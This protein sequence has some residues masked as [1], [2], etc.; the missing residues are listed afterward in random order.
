MIMDEPPVLSLII[1]AYNEG[2]RL[3]QTLPQVISFIVAQ[4]YPAEVLVVNNNSQD[5]TRAMLGVVPQDVHL[6]NATIEDNLLLADAHAT[7]EEIERACAVAQLDALMEYASVKPAVNQIEVSPFHQQIDSQ[8]FFEENSISVEAWAPFAEGRKNIFENE[9]YTVTTVNNGREC[10]NELKKGFNGI[11]ILD[12]MM[13]VMDR[14][15]NIKNMVIE[16][17]I[18]NNK[19]I[20]LTVKKIQGEEFY[21]YGRVSGG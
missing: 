21:R 7:R 8:K 5:D 12:I 14:I 10:L 1:P 17:F 6:F 2:Q 9:K 3:P 4:S 20:V 18:D 11:I 16:G 13:P 15:E 19:I